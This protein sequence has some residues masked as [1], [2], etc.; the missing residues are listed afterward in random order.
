MIYNLPDNENDFMNVFS[1]KK[2]VSGDFILL[3]E[4]KNDYKNLYPNLL[5]DNRTLNYLKEKAI[6]KKLIQKKV[7]DDG[8]EVLFLTDIGETQ[9]YGKFDIE[10]AFDEFMLII[11]LLDPDKNN[12]KITSF[13]VS[14]LD[15][16]HPMNY[17]NIKEI[18]KYARNNGFI[19][20]KDS[21]DP[22]MY[23]TSKGKDYINRTLKCAV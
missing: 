15:I 11:R 4:F 3:E 19:E 7:Y 10:N 12:Y 1:Y 13:I 5:I 6:E 21:L 9:I 16:M 14:V 18:L 20:Y 22:T 8:T 17:K 2:L 23:I